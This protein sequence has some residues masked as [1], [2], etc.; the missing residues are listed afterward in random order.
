MAQVESVETKKGRAQTSWRKS[1]KGKGSQEGRRA[2]R[3]V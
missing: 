2:C 1:T 3:G